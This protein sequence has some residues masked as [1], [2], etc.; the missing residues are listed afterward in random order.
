MPKSAI[1]PVN[2]PEFN[3]RISTFAKDSV[4]DWPAPPSAPQ[5]APNVLIWMLD[6]VGFGQIGAFGGLASTPN[7]DRVAAR[8]LVYNN[9]HATSLCSPSRAAL[10]TGRNHH[11]VHIGS[12]AAAPSGFPGYD[13]IIP[14]SAATTARILRD[15]GY[16]MMAIGK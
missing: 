9:F 10:L 8:G 5:N 15:Y 4:P 7:I 6:D 2:A 1:Q 12:H 3:G 13:D 16:S 11:A 14:K